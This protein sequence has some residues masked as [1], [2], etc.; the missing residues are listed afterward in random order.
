MLQ[1]HYLPADFLRLSALPGPCLSPCPLNSKPLKTFV[2][3]WEFCM[4]SNRL[5]H[6]VPPQIQEAQQE[7]SKIEETGVKA[8]GLYQF[9]LCGSINIIS[10]TV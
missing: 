3:C 1:V 10:V 6:S 5:L 9:G 7:G 4:R 8:Q 2:V